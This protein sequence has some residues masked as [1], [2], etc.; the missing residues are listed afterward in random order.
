MANLDM[1]EISHLYYGSSV[2]TDEVIVTK[3]IEYLEPDNR[4]FLSVDLPLLSK[5]HCILSLRTNRNVYE[6]PN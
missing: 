4:I 1:L 2:Y 5:K 3:G 6:T